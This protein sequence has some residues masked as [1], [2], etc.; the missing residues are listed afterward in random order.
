[1]NMYE[2]PGNCVWRN[3]TSYHRVFGDISRVIVVDKL[4][5]ERLTEE[6][7]VITASKMQT[8]TTIGRLPVGSFVPEVIS[9]AAITIELHFVGGL[10][11]RQLP[12]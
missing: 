4:M 12:A 7:Q 10:Q 2:C 5:R 11:L 1:M 8:Q 3:A 9:V 6:P